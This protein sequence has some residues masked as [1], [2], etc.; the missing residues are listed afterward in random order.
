MSVPAASGA[1]EPPPSR[2]YIE[3]TALLGE[4][5]AMARRPAKR[6]PERPRRENGSH[7]PPPLT[8]RDKIIAAFVALLAEH[9]FEDIGFADLAARAGVSL[10]VLRG[11]FGAKLPIY[12]AFVKDID[13]KVLAGGD[14]DMAEE[15][16]RER[17]FDVLMRRL[18]A[19]A[20]HKAA[21]RSLL[22]SA[23]RHPSL[24]FALNGVAV[25]SQQWMLTAANIDAAGP[26]GMV[27]AQG[28][29]LLFAGVLRTFVDDE[30]DGLA[31][32]MA[33]LDRALAR[34]QRWSG[35]LDDLCRFAPRGR[36]LSRFRRRRRDEERDGDPGRDLGEEPIPI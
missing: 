27:R 4:D 30:D 16:P 11:E 24:A 1:L 22:R 2:D 12:A 34:G 28:V 32:T 17:L 8:D 35:F 33:A 31:R 21:I 15:P 7:N 14:A 3:T 19:L 23:R 10:A 20:P 29:A 9:A 6:T 26:R 13:R 36:C 5:P 18:E 25:R